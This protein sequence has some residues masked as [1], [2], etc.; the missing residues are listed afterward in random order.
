MGASSHE[1]ASSPQLSKPPGT[2]DY[3]NPR[4]N[5]REAAKERR[6]RAAANALAEQSRL[7]SESEQKFTSSVKAPGISEGVPQSLHTISAKWLDTPIS[8]FAT[9]AAKSIDTL[10]TPNS[11]SHLHTL[12][13]V[14]HDDKVLH[15]GAGVDND[16]SQATNGGPVTGSAELSEA[17]PL[18]TVVS[19]K[20]L[21]PNNYAKR[22]AR[23]DVK[24][25]STKD[26]T[27]K[28]DAPGYTSKQ[29]F[30]EWDGIDR[31]TLT[32]VNGD[33][34]CLLIEFG[35][36]HRVSYNP[37]GQHLQLIFTPTA[38]LGIQAA[39]IAMNALP[40]NEWVE[41]Q[42]LFRQV[43]KKWHIKCDQEDMSFFDDSIKSMRKKPFKKM[44]TPHVNR[45]DIT[46]Q[47]TAEKLPKAP[48]QLSL[49]T[50]SRRQSLGPNLGT[51]SKIVKTPKNNVER[52]KAHLSVEVR[53]IMAAKLHD[54]PPRIPRLKTP[55]KSPSVT[56]NLMSRTSQS[57]LKEGTES[58]RSYYDRDSPTKCSTGSQ[59][60]NQVPQ[61]SATPGRAVSPNGLSSLFGSDDSDHD[62]SNFGQPDR[63]PSQRFTDQMNDA[64]MLSSKS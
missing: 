30:L 62:S 64:R 47:K 46:R 44:E 61:S 10:T 27:I 48:H 11:N 14:C 49:P 33:K 60:R 34:E 17:T 2:M 40:P 3:R 59:N 51:S 22:G 35:T 43:E 57:P 25:L 8:G 20:K 16:S 9:E 28:C 32:I 41:L 63:T 19:P 42:Q 56:S 58:Q 36:I 31:E 5:T 18:A 1:P 24:F 26:E 12:P 4:Q 39:V 55:S 7:G 21:S 6:K 45:S 50:A 52:P 15:Q 37:T 29:M 23:Y 53:N 13:A 38:Q 54:E